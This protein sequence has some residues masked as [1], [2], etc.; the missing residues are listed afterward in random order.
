MSLSLVK[1]K[2][3]SWLKLARLQFYPMAW[4]A[5]TIGAASA[6]RLE[7]EFDSKVYILGYVCVLLI[8]LCTVFCNEYFDFP[9]DSINRNASLFTGGSRVLVAQ[10]LSFSEIRAAIFVTICLLLIFG[11][12]LARAFE[13]AFSVIVILLIGLFLGSGYTALPFKFSYRGLGEVVV[14][15]TFGPYLIISGFFCRPAMYIAQDPGF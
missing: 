5:Y 7:Q 3:F 6:A 14:A 13:S 11:Y 12:L 8:E 2:I 10:K 9:T 15:V 1:D 4:I